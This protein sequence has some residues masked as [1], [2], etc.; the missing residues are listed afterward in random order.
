MIKVGVICAGDVELEPFLSH[1]QNC[2][3]TEK[4]MLKIYEGQINGIPITTLYNG[5]CKVNAAIATQIL[6]DT[7]Q[8]DI[9][10]NAGTA[11]E[12]DNKV[13]IFDTIISTQV[14]YHDV[15][16]NILIEF[17]P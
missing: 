15:D 6:I 10:I 5:V 17:H 11:G 2:S 1:I 12:M 16:D 14:A 8:V 7:Y 4:A 3:I 13:E 9:I